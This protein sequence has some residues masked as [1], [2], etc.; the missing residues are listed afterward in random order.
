MDFTRRP[1]WE[2]MTRTCHLPSESFWWTPRLITIITCWHR[3]S[4]YVCIKVVSAR[5]SSAAE[6]CN[7]EINVLRT[8]HSKSNTSDRH[9]HHIVKFIDG[10]ILRGPH[11]MHDCIVTEVLGNSLQS[12]HVDGRGVLPLSLLKRVSWQ[13]LR[14]LEWLHEECG[15]VHGC[16]EMLSRRRKR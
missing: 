10:F 5:D 12:F 6:R 2:S 3:T 16:K 4:S 15:I 7:S 14:A 1:G 11:G 13:L 9:D 8:I